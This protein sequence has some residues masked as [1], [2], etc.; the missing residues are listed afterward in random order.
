MILPALLYSL[1]CIVVGF[2]NVSDEEITYF[3]MPP[4]AFRLG[5]LDFWVLTNLLI[6]LLVVIIYTAAFVAAKKLGKRTRLEQRR[7]PS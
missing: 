1:A 2:M 3:C 5:A 7:K 6:C 4:T